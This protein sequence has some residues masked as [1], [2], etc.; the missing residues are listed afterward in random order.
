MRTKLIIIFSLIFSIGLF[1]QSKGSSAPKSFKIGPNAKQ[2]QEI[3][4]VVQYKSDVDFNV[5]TSSKTK[6]NT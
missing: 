2:E 3:A 5:P 6:T 1:A 4:P